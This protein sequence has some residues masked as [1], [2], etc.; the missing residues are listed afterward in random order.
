MSRLIRVGVVLVAVVLGSAMP[1]AHE[2]FGFVGPVVRTDLAKNRFAISYVE[3]R[4]A[5]TIEIAITPKTEIV[6][7]GKKVTKAELKKGVHVS[8]RAL[9]DDYSNL[10][11]YAIQILPA[12]TKE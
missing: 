5:E 6:R 4:K 10:E 2:E 3:N 1:G 8:V 9:G 12:P 11:A 7:A